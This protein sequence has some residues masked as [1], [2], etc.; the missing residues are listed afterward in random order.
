MNKKI[1]FG[2]LAGV[3]VITTVIFATLSYKYNESLKSMYYFRDQEKQI[4][5][6]MAGEHYRAD[7]NASIGEA[8][9]YYKEYS[10][11]ERGISFIYPQWWGDVH[12]ADIESDGNTMND[13]S[14][15][16]LQTAQLS[17]GL[18]SEWNALPAYTD[19]PDGQEDLLRFFGRDTNYE[20]LIFCKRTELNGQII[21]QSF[22]GSST[23]LDAR[24][25]YG[26]IVEILIYSPDKKMRAD[27]RV[28]RPEYLNCRNCG[29]SY[30]EFIKNQRDRIKTFDACFKGEARI[31]KSNPDMHEIISS[32][33]LSDDE[34][35]ALFELDNFIKSIKIKG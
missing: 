19:C 23:G 27:V 15:R 4:S 8:A 29:I 25:S 28:D 33:Q 16:F 24:D 31:D 21:I 11:Y 18:F 34:T 5:S 22:R 32:C 26:V 1:L 12:L 20:D 6:E 3:V 13:D 35:R 10:N 7:N 2:I 14:I 9:D 30:K 17:I